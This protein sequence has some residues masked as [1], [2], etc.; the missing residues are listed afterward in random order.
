MGGGC[1]L[2]FE[3]SRVDDS[4]RRELIRANTVVEQVERGNFI[5]LNRLW[6]LLKSSL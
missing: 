5:F 3:T 2:N 6:G 1:L 4:S